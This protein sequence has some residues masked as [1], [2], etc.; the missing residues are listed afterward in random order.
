[1][2]FSTLLLAILFAVFQSLAQSTGTLE[3]STIQVSLITPVGTNGKNSINTINNISLN[4]FGGYHSGLNGAEF[5]SFANLNRDFMNGFQFSGMVN[6]TGG[7]A[8][9]AQFAG[10]SNVNLGE[11]NAFQFAGITNVNHGNARAF[12]FAGITNVNLGSTQIFQGAGVINFTMGNSHLIQTAG[13]ANYA[14]GITGA[15]LSG[16]TNFA[17]K[18][19]I[20]AQITGV[21]NAA[22][23]IEGLQL[24]GIVNAAKYVRGVQLA[25]ILNVAKNVD[26]VQ[27]GVVNVADTVRNGVP[28]GILSIVRDG[29]HEFELGISEGL[30]SY[31]SFKIGVPAFYNIFSIGTQFLSNQF[32]W[33]VGYGIGTHLRNKEDFKVNLELMSYHIN[34]G[35]TWT[36]EYNGL[37][38]L[39]VT[40]AGGNNKHIQFFAG[41]TLNLMVSK[42]TN[43]DGSVGSDFPPYAFSNTMNGNT[44]LKF[45]LGFNAGVL[46]H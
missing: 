18:D 6:Y 40:F 36:N 33:G 10:I 17:L 44:N 22:K 8:S 38:Q 39:K 29:F 24:A 20:G 42:Y 4:I 5:G 46:F 2:K 26:G 43:E 41:P 30:N 28:I 14:E 19:A 9:G 21:A 11:T 45:W 32:R 16:V 3:K 37:Q 15:Q 7:E 25:A 1:M 23:S 31:G 34:E 35:S 27:L 12:Q 13:V